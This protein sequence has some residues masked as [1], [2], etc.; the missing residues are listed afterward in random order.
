[1]VDDNVDVAT[2]TALLLQEYGCK[3]AVAYSGEVALKVALRF[4]PNVV[5]ID[6]RMSDEDGCDILAAVR[7]LDGPVATALCVCVT[8]ED[9]PEVRARC[10]AAGFDLFIS[11]P[12]ETSALQSALAE[13]QVRAAMSGES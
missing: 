4:Q 12:I 11:K 5:F 9:T 6:L 13:A 1:M 8:G 10:L 3:T 7:R 2:M